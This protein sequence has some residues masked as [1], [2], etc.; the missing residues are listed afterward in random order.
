MKRTNDAGSTDNV[1]TPKT[2]RSRVELVPTV[3]ADLIEASP[4]TPLEWDRAGGSSDAE[5]KETLLILVTP[6][7]EDMFEFAGAA[8]GAPDDASALDDASS[9][10]D[11]IVES[12]DD[13]SDVDFD[14]NALADDDNDNGG[15]R[16]SV[17]VEFGDSSDEASADADAANGTGAATAG[18]A[19]SGQDDDDDDGGDNSEDE[20]V[21]NLDASS[22]DEDDSESSPDPDQSML[23]SRILVV[24]LSASSGAVAFNKAFYDALVRYESTGDARPLAGLVLLL[25]GN[26]CNHLTSV[27]GA[28]A[29]ADIDNKSLIGFEVVVAGPGQTTQEMHPSPHL[30]WHQETTV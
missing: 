12:D 20:D 5:R 19:G 10:E 29:V 25:M 14:P 21:D 30:I 23:V 9:D 7:I 15:D 4:K 18:S 8:I 22:D 27:F 17:D 11:D 13:E 26:R 16:K 2:K 28:D 1:D 3:S 6:T 24:S